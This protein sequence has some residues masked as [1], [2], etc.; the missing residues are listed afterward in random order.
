VPGRDFAVTLVQA[1]MDGPAPLKLVVKTDRSQGLDAV[2]WA[3][4]TI[5][6][7]A[8]IPRCRRSWIKPANE[9][10][11]ERNFQPV[12][13]ATAG[14]TASIHGKLRRVRGAGLQSRIVRLGPLGIVGAPPGGSV[15]LMRTCGRGE[16]PIDFH[17]PTR[18]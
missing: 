1:A 11:A 13:H 12:P 14:A 9:L 5:T 16:H 7:V 4:R 8:D 15:K 3:H 17:Q 18:W 2:N 10:P 6:G